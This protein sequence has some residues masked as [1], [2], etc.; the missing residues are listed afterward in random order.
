MFEV[1]DLTVSYGPVKAVQNVSLSI[2]A[3]EIVT[4]IGANGA[5]KSSTLKAISGAV[6]SRIGKV[7]LDGKQIDHIKTE[8]LPRLGLVHVPEGRGIFPNLTVEENLEVA[9]AGA[10][11]RSSLG[12]NTKKVYELLPRLEERKKQ[13]AWSLSGGE[14]QMLALGRAIVA[15][16]RILLLDEPSLGLAPLVVSMI[17][18][19]ILEIRNGGTGILLVEQNANLALNVADRAYVMSQGVITLSGT[20]EQVAT[21]SSVM[22]AYLGT[23]EEIVEVEQA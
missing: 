7:Y 18:E 13:G 9:A 2:G 3:R 4:L 10:G 6:S 23:L 14:Q 20:A 15:E 21:D 1:R 5:G 12:K 19:A 8:K 16:P 11:K 22:D 17:F